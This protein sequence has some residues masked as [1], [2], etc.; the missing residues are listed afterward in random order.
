MSLVRIIQNLTWHPH[1]KHSVFPLSRPRSVVQEELQLL[2]NSCNVKCCPL[3]LQL[4][5]GLQ[6]A[7][8]G[9]V[10]STRERRHIRHWE[11]VMW[12]CVSPL[13]RCTRRLYWMFKCVNVLPL[14]LM[15]LLWKGSVG[16]HL[17]S[18]LSHLKPKVAS[19]AWIL[20]VMKY[21]GSRRTPFLWR[22]PQVLLALLLT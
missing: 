5:S 8:W 7:G 19:C 11:W 15:K 10:W 9:W 20:Q 1:W 16:S 13:S 3:S 21:R 6:S 14:Q 22:Y 17:V 4:S 2:Q 18:R 12:L